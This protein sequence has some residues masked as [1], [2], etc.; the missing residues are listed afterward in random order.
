[1]H[2]NMNIKFEV[3]YPKITGTNLQ[4]P[5]GTVASI[6]T[7]FLLDGSLIESQWETRFS[8]SGRTETGADL[9]FYKMGTKSP[10]RG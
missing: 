2:G 8:T 5:R 3:M 1:M 9:A 7:R 10:S 4:V 6:A